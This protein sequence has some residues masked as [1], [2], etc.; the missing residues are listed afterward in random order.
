MFSRKPFDSRQDQV[1]CSMTRPQVDGKHHYFFHISNHLQSLL[2][3]TKS[4]LILILYGQIPIFCS[5]KTLFCMVKS[6]FHPI[7]HVS[8][9]NI[10]HFPGKILDLLFSLSNPPMFMENFLFFTIKNP[11]F[12]VK[13]L[14][15]MLKSPCST[16]KMGHFQHFH[17]FS[18]V[19]STQ[20]HQNPPF[21]LVK[22]G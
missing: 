15:S 4:Y 20:I 3:I 5:Q 9:G 13:T 18:L 14:F 17:A 7:S 2:F 11:P 22:P 19:K 10:H 16:A 21:S 8:H 12:P 6:L 1:L